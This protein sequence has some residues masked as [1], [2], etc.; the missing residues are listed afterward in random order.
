MIEVKLKGTTDFA[1]LSFPLK[2]KDLEKIFVAIPSAKK[3]NIA[4]LSTINAVKIYL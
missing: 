4:I 1:T 3:D 2:E